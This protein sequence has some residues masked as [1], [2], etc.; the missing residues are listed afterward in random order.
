[1]LS[2]LQ[3]DNNIT[4][5]GERHKKAN[6]TNADVGGYPANIDVGH[7]LLLDDVLQAG[8]RQLLV[9]KEGGVGVDIGVGAL[10]KSNSGSDS[11]SDS[12]QEMLERVLAASNGPHSRKGGQVA[13]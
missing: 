8:L 2:M 4:I 1:M 10:A 7:V 5:Q 3:A 6:I 13:P 12:S 11:G 9:V